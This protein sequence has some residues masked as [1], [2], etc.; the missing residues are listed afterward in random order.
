[1]CFTIIIQSLQQ[2]WT[3]L[4]SVAK[5]DLDP[6]NIVMKYFS[7][8]SGYDRPCSNCVNYCSYGLD[9]A[10]INWLAWFLRSWQSF[11]HQSW[12]NWLMSYFWCHMP[13][14]KSNVIWC[15]IMHM[16]SKYDISQFCQS[17][18]LKKRWDHSFTTCGS[19][20]A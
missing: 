16:T 7:S 14:L 2:F 15:Q 4:M 17:W 8:P 11:R 20:L 5:K 13:H 3:I 10:H 9:N 12:L 18:C 19:D 1:M 6:N